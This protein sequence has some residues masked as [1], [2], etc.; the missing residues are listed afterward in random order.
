MSARLGGFEVIKTWLK[1]IHV[2]FGLDVVNAAKMKN[3]I[4]AWFAGRGRRII[5]P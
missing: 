3:V 2:I 1:D 5:I 4:I